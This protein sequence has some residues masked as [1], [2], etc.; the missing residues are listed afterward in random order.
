MR[1]VVRV[2][3]FF[4]IRFRVVVCYWDSSGDFILGFVGFW[5]R[6]LGRDFFNTLSDLGKGFSGFVCKMG[7]VLNG[8]VFIFRISWVGVKNVDEEELRFLVF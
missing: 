3:V 4:R 8:Y 1:G 5:V 6:G 7:L 2:L